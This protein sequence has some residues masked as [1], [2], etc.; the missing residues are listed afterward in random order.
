MS[1]KKISK[2]KKKSSSPIFVV[3]KHAASHLHWD[4]RLELDGVLK[5]WAIPKEPSM[6]P[7]VK[8]LAV[9]V[10]DHDLSYASFQGTIEEGHYGAGKV[11]LWDNGTY[12]METRKDNKM[13]FF[14]HGKK[15]KGRFTILKFEKAGPKNWL[16]FKTKEEHKVKE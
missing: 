12:E 15:L 16:F 3:Q 10:T 6:D 11:E 13:V 1:A 14:L 9:Q 4:F 2:K 7:K 8:K 5:S